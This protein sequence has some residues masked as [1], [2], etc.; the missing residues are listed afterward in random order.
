LQLRPDKFDSLL[1][2]SGPSPV[3]LLDKNYFF[4]YN[5]AR[6]WEPSEKPGWTI[7][8]NVGFAIID[9]KNPLRILQRSEEP[10][11]SP[12]EPW[13]KGTAFYPAFVPNAIFAE[14]I[15]SLGNNKF[16]VF[17]GCADTTVGSATI[18][19]T[20]NEQTGAYSVTAQKHARILNRTPYIAQ[21]TDGT[22]DI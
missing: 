14:G 7:Q 4:I 8:Y 17:Y 21:F 18:T 19:V 12:T 13:E 11:L 5:S 22:C 2:E 1:V 10:L 6:Q 16:V 20:K 3:E 15:K 9:R